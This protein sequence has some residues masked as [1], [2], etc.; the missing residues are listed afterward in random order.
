VSDTLLLFKSKK[1]KM[2]LFL[3]LKILI[4]WFQAAKR[5]AIYE[6]QVDSDRMLS[7]AEFYSE[8]LEGRSAIR[9]LK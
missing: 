8:Q 1:K 2:L 9:D 5:C 4:Y 3:V 7:S 6:A